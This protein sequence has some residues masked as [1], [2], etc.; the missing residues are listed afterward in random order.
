MALCDIKKYEYL[1]SIKPHIGSWLWG[2]K[3]CVSYLDA[4]SVIIKMTILPNS[5]VV[6][7]G[8]FMV[9]VVVFG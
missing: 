6:E 2:Y 5:D 7:D 3:L 9:M 1:I 4:G 8:Q